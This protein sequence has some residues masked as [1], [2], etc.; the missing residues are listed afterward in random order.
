MASVNGLSK[1][2]MLEIEA[3][4]IVDG[5]VNVNG[6]LV[7][8]RHDG[9]SFTA[10]NIK[11]TRTGQTPIWV[12]GDAL[13]SEVH[14]ADGMPPRVGDLV[15]GTN[16]FDVGQLSYVIAVVDS[17]HADLRGFVPN[18]NVKGPQGDVG[19]AGPAGADG[20]NADWMA[21]NG[22]PDPGLGLPGDWYLDKLTS[23]VYEKDATNTWVLQTNIKGATGATGPEGPTGPAGAA[24]TG[25]SAYP[26]GAVYIAVVNTS[27]ETL[28][29]G[30]W[31]AFGTGRMLVGIDAAQTEFDTVEETGGSKTKVIGTTNL[32]PHTHTATAAA[33]GAH[34]HSLN[35]TDAGASGA[36][37]SRGQT[38]SPVTSN[39]SAVNESATHTHSITVGNGPGTSAPMDV[40][41]PYIVVYMWKRTA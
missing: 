34:K 14:F 1:E 3:A 19:P 8:T 6:D 9:T 12:I 25:L 21:A 38:G 36:N 16:G 15:I 23:D 5:E 35:F 26:V 22:V 32:P 10:G 18:I 2:R 37:V 17:T 41:N 28:F 27:P 20:A 11:G 31:V 40:L 30:T 7:L 4:S 24:G 39:S 13:N 33:D 29:G